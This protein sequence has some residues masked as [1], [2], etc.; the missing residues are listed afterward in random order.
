MIVAGDINVGTDKW[1][2]L[3]KLKVSCFKCASKVGFRDDEELDSQP[4]CMNLVKACILACE[5]ARMAY[6]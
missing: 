6:R 5:G 4:V 1:S 3:L 2:D